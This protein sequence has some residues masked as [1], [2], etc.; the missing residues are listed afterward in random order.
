MIFSVPRSLPL[1]RHEEGRRFSFH[2]N[3]LYAVY[4]YS[5]TLYISRPTTGM[6]G[7]GKTIECR[8]NSGFIPISGRF[9][10]WNV[11]GNE[12]DGGGKLPLSTIKGSFKRRSHTGVVKSRV[13]SLDGYTCWCQGIYDAGGFEGFFLPL[14]GV[15]T[16]FFASTMRDRLLRLF[17][18]QDWSRE[19]GLKEVI[20][21]LGSSLSLVRFW[22]KWG[23]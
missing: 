21:V 7:R 14:E 12:G 4:L 11:R 23:L 17:V 9:L 22:Y 19:V 6:Q 8:S 18:G 1:F 20:G 5:Y 13:P 15:E 2:I 16:R 10:N 3:G